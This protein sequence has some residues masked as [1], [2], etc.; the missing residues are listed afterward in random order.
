MGAL[1]LIIVIVIIFTVST[2]ISDFFYELEVARKK[3]KEDLLQIENKKKQL[4]FAKFKIDE[5][6]KKCNK[7][8]DCLGQDFD[9]YYKQ[10]YFQR[11]EKQQRMKI[12][13]L[14]R[15]S[16]N[17]SYYESLNF[18]G[19]L[20]F[21]KKK[22]EFFIS[23]P[24]PDRRYNHKEF[25]LINIDIGKFIIELDKCYKKFVELKGMVP[26]GGNYYER[27][28]FGLSIEFINYKSGINFNDYDTVKINDDKTFIMQMADLKYAWDMLEKIY[29]L[30]EL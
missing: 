19:Y 8:F 17:N 5:I 3:K 7:I 14:I 2:A 10:I 24:G 21:Y 1:I 13:N 28:G 23:F 30:S 9:E 15:T 4:E 11:Y 26:E 18:R 25:S 29:G 6:K 22:L 20:Y 16:S 12:Q 27:F